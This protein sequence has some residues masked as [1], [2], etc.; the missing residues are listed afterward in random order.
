MNTTKLALPFLIFAGLGMLV[1]PSQANAW[2]KEGHAIVAA[3][4]DAHLSPSARA[5]VARLLAVE[6]GS[7][8]ESVASWAD[9]IRRTDRST[10]GWHF[11]DFPAGDCTYRP[12]VEC[13]KGNCLVHAV[14]VQMAI[15]ADKSLPD[16]QREVALK[17]VI[18]LAGDAAQPLHNWGPQRGGNGYQVQFDGRGTNIHAVWDT[19]LIRDA[20]SAMRSTG[21]DARSGS[22]IDRLFGA[23]DDR[24]NRTRARFSGERYHANDQ[25]FTDRL[26]KASKT[27]TFT[28]DNDPV[29]WAESA[30]MVANRPGM[31]PARV[32]P[33][34][35]KQQWEPVMEAELIE[36]GMHLASVLNSEL[37]SD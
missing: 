2:G 21:S 10:A 14:Q 28:V 13:R 22:A 11:T 32:V 25:A 31:F 18:H 9:E 37:G 3:I 4:A 36:G 17:W 7:T 33:D 12:P 6:P 20:A 8:M 24:A 19:G 27:M 15:L 5:E 30:C 35:Y 29:H 1:A 26:I 34:S 23:M 16:A